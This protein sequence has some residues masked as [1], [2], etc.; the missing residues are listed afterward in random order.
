MRGRGLKPVTADP[1]QSIIRSPPVRGR[2]LKR[3]E[4]RHAAQH[5][6]VA[7]RAGARIE[8]VPNALRQARW[9]SGADVRRQIQFINNVFEV[10]A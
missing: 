9:V 2:G 4:R 1:N 3:R 7:P 6:Q 8:T 5:A 10:A